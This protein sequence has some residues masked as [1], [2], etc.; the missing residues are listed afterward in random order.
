MLR[1]AISDHGA[2]FTTCVTVP[3]YSK[4]VTVI[5]YRVTLPTSTGSRT[6]GCSL[7]WSS[8]A[9]WAAQ[10][11]AQK[12]ANRCNTVNEMSNQIHV[13]ANLSFATNDWGELR[14]WSAALNAM[15]GEIG[16]VLG[17]R[18]PSKS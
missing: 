15:P 12:R 5:I 8:A 1:T 4:S 3:Y 6:R 16:T 7:R 10:A 11:D 18:E 9:H 2:G 17:R 13:A 14:R